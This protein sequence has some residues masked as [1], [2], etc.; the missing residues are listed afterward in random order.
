MFDSGTAHMR[1]TGNS[2]VNWLI[3]ETADSISIIR[4]IDYDDETG[5]GMPTI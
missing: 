5:N 2:A 1:I 3:G 4:S